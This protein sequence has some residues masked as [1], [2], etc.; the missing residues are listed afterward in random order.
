MIPLK[1]TAS[2][3]LLALSQISFASEQQ[4]KH[5]PLQRSGAVRQLPPTIDRSFEEAKET[6]NEK[7]VAKVRHEFQK[8]KNRKKFRELV[9][10]RLA[11]R[12]RTKKPL[13]PKARLPH[14]PLETMEAKAE[15]LR[16]EKSNLK[17]RLA[18]LPTIHETNE[19]EL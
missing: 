4:S 19:E 17:Q 3:S 10:Q 5:A 2:L 11:S 7:K 18:S 1:L 15:K 16:V 14:L 12:N 8:R 9:Q 6:E 13:S